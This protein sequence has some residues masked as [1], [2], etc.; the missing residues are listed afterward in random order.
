M[1]R[2]KLLSPGLSCCHQLSQELG[3]VH[4]L[5]PLLYFCPCSSWGCLGKS[6]DHAAPQQHHLLL[7]CT[8][9]SGDKQGHF[10]LTSQA[11]AVGRVYF[12]AIYFES[13]APRDV[14]VGCF[15]NIDNVWGSGA[16]DAEKVGEISTIEASLN[17]RERA[18]SITHLGNGKAMLHFLTSLFPAECIFFSFNSSFW[19]F[20]F[21]GSLNFLFSG[22]LDVSEKLNRHYR[23]YLQIYV[24]IDTCLYV[25]IDLRLCELSGQNKV[26]E[27]RREP[28]LIQ[29]MSP[30]SGRGTGCGTAA[31][32]KFWSA[33]PTV[34]SSSV[35]GQF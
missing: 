30:S 34:P 5:N 7:H 6:T 4:G 23:Q 26:R 17:Q 2:R 28:P 1:G 3:N 14:Y 25:H 33:H 29:E 20:L 10:C 18:N 31:T 24:C 27:Q 16:W 22:S 12:S 35:Q 15:L 32:T 11:A 21:S 9:K 13:P 8:P 19:R